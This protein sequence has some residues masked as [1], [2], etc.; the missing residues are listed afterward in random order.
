MRAIVPAIGLLLTCTI[1]T[2]SAQTAPADPSPSQPA[3]QPN[4]STAFSALPESPAVRAPLYT[5]KATP[6]TLGQRFRLQASYSFGI[7]AYVAPA[8]ETGYTMIRPP[9]NYPRDWTDGA[10]AF[11][12]NYGA[13]L[14]RHTTAGMTH[15]AVAAA[16]HEDPRYYRCDCTNY[17][18]R[19]AHALAYTIVDRTAPTVALDGRILPGHLTFATSN[20]AGSAAGGFVGMAYEPAGFNDV[21]HSYQRAALEL[22]RFGIRNLRSEFTPEIHEIVVKLH[23]PRTAAKT[24][25][26]PPSQSQPPTPPKPPTPTTPQ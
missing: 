13:L 21:T 7:G 19:I 1:L 16:L 2:A 17:F 14:A 9:N 22:P 18:A 10:A 8:F 23:I 15:F 5:E 11:G 6:I 12:R 25:T 24:V 26:L 3:Q 4:P 20:F